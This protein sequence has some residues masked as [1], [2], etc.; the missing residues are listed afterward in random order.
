MKRLPL[1]NVKPLDSRRN[2]MSKKY[3][4]TIMEYERGWGSRVDEI[5][6]FDTEEDRDAFVKD[7]NSKNTAD[8]A[9]D[10]YMVAVA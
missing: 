7:F 5:R 10:W 3:T 8:T 2:F 4:A 9:P 1:L 6:E